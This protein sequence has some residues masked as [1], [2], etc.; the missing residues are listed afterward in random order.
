[1]FESSFVAQYLITMV[2]WGLLSKSDFER[3]AGNNFLIGLAII[4]H[5]FPIIV[6]TISMILSKMKFRKD[7]FVKI[8]IFGLIYSF[9][10][11]LQT[12]ILVRKPYN[13]LTWEGIDSVIAVLVL[14]VVFGSFYV[15]V[16]Y[17]LDA[18]TSDESK[19]KDE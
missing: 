6:A 16:C 15:L 17:I 10:N 3:K 5:S 12:M 19:K 4:Q 8:T 14:I 2:Y 11:F 1:M 18:I 13:F 9:N 7:D